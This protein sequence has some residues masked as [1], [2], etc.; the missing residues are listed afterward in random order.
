VRAPAALGI[1]LLLLTALPLSAEMSLHSTVPAPELPDG[2]RPVLSLTIGGGGADVAGW[3]V[4]AAAAALPPAGG[5]PSAAASSR[6]WV[7]PAVPQVTVPAN[8][9]AFDPSIDQAT[10]TRWARD[11]V[12]DLMIESE[13][14]RA[15]DLKLAEDGAEGDGLKEFTDVIRQDISGGKS[16]LKTYTF[17]RVQLTLFLP[18]LSTQAS[19]LVGVTLHGTQTLVTRD[20]TGKVLSRTTQ[21]YSKSWGL[22]GTPGGPDHIIND[23]SDLKLA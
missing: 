3:T 8:V 16:V 18:K 23:Y 2:T 19:R 15:H 1:C 6:V 10:A 20:S 11:V 22:E 14:R 9:T 5:S 4:G 12:L 17:D 13:A 7:L 21:P